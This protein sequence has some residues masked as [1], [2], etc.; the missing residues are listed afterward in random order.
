[1][2]LDLIDNGNKLISGGVTTD[3]CIYDLDDGRFPE[4]KQK[5]LN[6]GAD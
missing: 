6:E 1:M 3:I 5:L 4:R 2:A